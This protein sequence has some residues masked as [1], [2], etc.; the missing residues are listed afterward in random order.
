MGSVSLVGAGPGD[1]DLITVK[2][3]KAIKSADVIL[4]DRLINHDLLDEAKKDA[5]LIYCG[6]L[7]QHHSMQQDEINKL[8]V[9][10]AKQGKH[11]VR[12][13]GGDPYI[14]G[15]GGEEATYVVKHGIPYDIIPGITS[16]IAAPAYAGIPVTHRDYSASFAIVTGHRKADADDSEKWA[17]LAKG[18]DTLVIYMGIKNAEHIQQQL[19]K[20]GKSP[21][22]PCA[23]IHWGTTDKQMTKLCTLQELNETIK[24]NQM[25][26]PSIIII[27]EVVKLREQLALLTEKAK[28]IR[29]Q[30]AII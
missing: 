20:Y 12:L 29:L 23:I 7:P 26:N 17:A 13:K 14:Y 2:G 24:R 10:H 3:L 18:I 22:I 5:K 27:G 21:Q 25:M 30:E 11:V 16:G 8:L 1:I 28:K 15:R 9:Q 6:K 4:Y 19:I